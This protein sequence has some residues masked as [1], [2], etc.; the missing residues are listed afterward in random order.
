LSQF[1]EETT[2]VDC[3][4]PDAAVGTDVAAAVAV[5]DAAVGTAANVGAVGTAANA[6]AVVVDCTLGA[7]VAAN[8]GDCAVDDANVMTDAIVVAA[9]AEVA[10]DDG[11]P[12]V[13]DANVLDSVADPDECIAV[14]DVVCDVAD[15]GPVS[16]AVVAS[17][18]LTE[19]AAEVD[20]GRKGVLHSSRLLA[21]IASS[22]AGSKLQFPGRIHD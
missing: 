2:V 20:V 16:A 5:A 1:A 7:A 22:S 11:G 18:F 3:D 21:T 14:L 8:N 12:A 9:V 13:V 17:E 15:N 6:G 10:V 4:I 19:A